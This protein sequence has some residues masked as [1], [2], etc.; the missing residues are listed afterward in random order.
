MNK[1]NY[2]SAEDVAIVMNYGIKTYSLYLKVITQP[3]WRS[4]SVTRGREDVILEWS[5]S[6]KMI[7]NSS[8]LVAG[9]TGITNQAGPC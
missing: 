6:H 3:N 7:A 5:N 4:S 9:K 1:L 2:S 8:L